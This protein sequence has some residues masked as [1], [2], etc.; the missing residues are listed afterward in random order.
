M[1][2]ISIKN[3]I[4]NLEIEI[5]DEKE[6][7]KLSK[8]API[9]PK[10]S[11]G[12]IVNY[13]RGMLLYA[14]ITKYKPKTVLEIGTAEGYSTLCM[15][16]AMTDNKINGKI[17]TVD[18]KSH[19]LRIERSIILEDESIIKEKLSTE[20][21]W[22]KFADTEWIEKIEVISGYAGEVL[23][24]NKFPKMEFGYIDGAHFYEAVKHDFYQFLKLADNKFSILF[25]DYVPGRTDGVSKVIDEEIN[26]NFDTVFIKTDA[27]KHRKEVGIDRSGDEQVM[28][29]I[30]S[31]SLK[32]N[33]WQIYPKEKIEEY[34]K[35]YLILEKRIKMR[36]K[37]DGK[38]PY[39]KNIKFQWWKK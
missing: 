8:I 32:S 13:E 20:E 17:F 26:N 19:H 23:N 12:G 27:R 31:N 1:K 3:L 33:I 6:F 22:N 38:I 25:D 4:K 24:N 36:K 28:C 9:N 16:W 30:E 15:A 10:H 34:I 5:P 35:K 11:Q 29:F 18:P 37:I 14:L 39:L 21:L 7:L 2:E